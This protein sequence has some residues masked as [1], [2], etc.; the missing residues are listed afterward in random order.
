LSMRIKV[1]TGFHGLYCW[2]FV[3]PE[4]GLQADIRGSGP[5]EEGTDSPARVEVGILLLGI[6]VVFL[7]YI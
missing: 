3:Q 7:H 6:D 1:A 5:E 4:T 2:S